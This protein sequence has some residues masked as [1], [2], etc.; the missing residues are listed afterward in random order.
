[1]KRPTFSALIIAR[2]EEAML[3]NCIA[4]LR[5]C[6]QI[7]V[8]DD[9]STDDTAKIA[10]QSGAKV[11]A[12][13]HNS[14]AR[15]REELLKRAQSDW[16]FYIDADER[17]VPTLAKE[18][19]VVAETQKADAMRFRRNNIYYGQLLKYGGWGS[20]FVTRAFKRE[21]LKGWFGDIHES[22]E[23]TGAIVDIKTPIIHLTHRDTASGLFKSAAW[24]PMEADAL[25]A[26]DTK[27][28]T[29]FT[30]FRKGFMEF[31]RR[32]VL[33][34]GFKEGMVGWIEALIQGMNR[35]LVYI[36]V[37]ERQQK[38]TIAEKYQK[39]ERDIQQ[40]WQDKE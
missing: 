30:I 33:K 22:P 31:L 13:R 10:E 16:V 4:T 19:M 7:L 40:L 3:A 29:F 6:N 21:S 12:F 38:P 32:A 2:N 28:V 23:F 25:A 11:I 26:A 37:W 34:R 24:T 9:G 17:V 18:M 14:F 39:T 35:M 1:M 8:L 36:Q 15:K 20:D 5:W 27:P